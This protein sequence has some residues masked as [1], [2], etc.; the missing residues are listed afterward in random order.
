MDW[1]SR[2]QYVYWAWLRQ[3][4]RVL[5]LIFFLARWTVGQGEGWADLPQAPNQ[6]EP[7]AG[8]RDQALQWPKRAAD[9]MSAG[10]E[11]AG[12]EKGEDWVDHD[13][14]SPGFAD[15]A[16]QERELRRQAEGHVV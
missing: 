5:A 1:P 9:R 7:E 6:Q 12:I 4:W 3:R 13:E 16:L 8:H 2:S 15:H 11:H 14:P 10:G